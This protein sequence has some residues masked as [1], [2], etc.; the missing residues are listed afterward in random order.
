MQD[1]KVRYIHTYI[2]NITGKI[3]RKSSSYHEIQDK[4]DVICNISSLILTHHQ[5]IESVTKLTLN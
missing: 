5:A 3:I 2:R 4:D 1:Q